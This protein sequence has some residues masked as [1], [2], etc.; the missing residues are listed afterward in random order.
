MSVRVGRIAPMSTPSAHC[1][2]ASS[3]LDRAQ[4]EIRALTERGTLTAAERVELARWQR[5]WVAAW[6]E[7]VARAA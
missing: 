1:V 7:S 6:R 3:R 5:E 4:A 2:C